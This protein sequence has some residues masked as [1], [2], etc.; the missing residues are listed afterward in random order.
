MSGTI[1]KIL[2]ADL[3]AQLFELLAEIERIQRKPGD[4]PPFDLAREAEEG[5]ADYFARH[6]GSQLAV[7]LWAKYVDPT[8]APLTYEE[9]QILFPY[10]KR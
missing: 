9:F 7:E 10:G 8:R 6:S 3:T 1:R 4:A 2:P 5:L